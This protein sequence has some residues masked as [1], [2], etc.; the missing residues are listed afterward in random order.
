M[1][2]VYLR[3]FE[4]DDYKITHQWRQDSEIMDPH[5]GNIHFVSAER[6]K[7]WIESITRDDKRSLYLAICLCDNNEMIGYCSINN[8][9][10]RNC[11]C[12]WGATTIGSKE[13]WGKGYAKEASQLMLKHIFQEYPIHRCYGY[14]LEE[15]AITRRMMSSLGFKQEGILREDVYKN[16]TFHNKCM[17]SILVDEYR[18]MNKHK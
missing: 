7:N 15:H 17:Y 3:A 5:C 14:C 10:L 13:H 12:E 4:I 2:N 1:G 18:E 16:G 8:I 11:K 6:E 9:D